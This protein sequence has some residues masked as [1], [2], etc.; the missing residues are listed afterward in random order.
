M[1]HVGIIRGQR[2]SAIRHIAPRPASVPISGSPRFEASPASRDKAVRES[3]PV[4]LHNWPNAAWC[5]QLVVRPARF[6]VRIHKPESCYCRDKQR[7]SLLRSSLCTHSLNS[8]PLAKRLQASLRKAAFLARRSFPFLC[9]MS[10][11]RRSSPQR[12]SQGVK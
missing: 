11:R 4:C 8:H 6:R 9:F 3:V 1:N 5:S 10:H 2:C 7:I 12:T